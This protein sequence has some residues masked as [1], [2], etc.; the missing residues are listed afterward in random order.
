VLSSLNKAK[1]PCLGMLQ[2]KY[3]QLNMQLLPPA[4]PKA[5][6]IIV[7]PQQRILSLHR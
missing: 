6:T 2:H 4:V 3:Q 5:A 7:I 1:I